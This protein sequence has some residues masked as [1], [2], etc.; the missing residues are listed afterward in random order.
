M[1]TVS[2]FSP[3][4]LSISRSCI[5]FVEVLRSD[6][7]DTWMTLK[8][9]LARS[10][11]TI[12]GLFTDNPLSVCIC[13]SKA[14]DE[15]FLIFSDLLNLVFIP[16]LW[17]FDSVML[18]LLL[19]DICSCKFRTSRYNMIYLFFMSSCLLHILRSGLVTITVRFGSEMSFAVNPAYKN[20]FPAI[21]NGKK[22]TSKTLKPQDFH[23]HISR[24]SSIQLSGNEFQLN[25]TLIA[26]LT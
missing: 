24:L 8:H 18:T 25:L 7:T 10:L 21:Q 20:P 16:L 1:G 4:I 5:S 26:S 9:H 6:G 23:S 2:V 14:K 12:S 13:I 22:K 15:N 19:M 17:Y 3:H 11:I